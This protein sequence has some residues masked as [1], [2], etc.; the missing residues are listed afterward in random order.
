LTHKIVSAHRG[1]IEIVSGPQGGSQ[2]VV[3]L[4]TVEDL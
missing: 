3:S 4:P 2:F 1:S